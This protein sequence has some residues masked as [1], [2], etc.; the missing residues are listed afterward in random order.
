MARG[1]ILDVV[2]QKSTRS[3]GRIGLK[4]IAKR[5]ERQRRGRPRTDRAG[6]ERTSA[7][8]RED[9]RPRGGDRGDRAAVAAATAARAAREEQRGAAARPPFSIGCVQAILLLALISAH[10]R[11][12][13]VAAAIARGVD[14]LV[15]LTTFVIGV[16]VLASASATA[17][18][19]PRRG[20][21]RP[22]RRRSAPRSPR[23]TRAAWG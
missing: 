16:L 3:A 17:A 1:D 2:V 23:S 21:G 6:E 18:S 8:E 4:L 12:R 9:E 15:A 19:E 5:R 7:R 11:D 13:G 14:G 20:A 22:Q 10:G